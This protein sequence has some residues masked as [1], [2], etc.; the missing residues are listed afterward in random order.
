MPNT[1]KY[2][3]TSTKMKLVVVASKHQASK[4]QA[5]SW[6]RRGYE[7]G[8]ATKRDF[9]A[10]LRSANLDESELCQVE[11]GTI[12]SRRTLLDGSSRVVQGSF[13][14]SC[15][16]MWLVASIPQEAQIRVN[17]AYSGLGHGLVKTIFAHTWE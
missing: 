13:V 2:M 6:L 15:S 4:H 11:H 10:G 12:R 14:I 17:L 3:N 9:E 7:T 16:E 8:F 5:S 1:V